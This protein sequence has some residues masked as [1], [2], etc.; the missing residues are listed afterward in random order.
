MDKTKHSVLKNALT[1]LMKVEFYPLSIYATF[2][3]VL[4]F[5]GKFA[6]SPRNENIVIVTASFPANTRAH[7]REI[8]RHRDRDRERDFVSLA[9]WMKDAAFGIL[10]HKHWRLWDYTQCGVLWDLHYVH[11]N[12]QRHLC[13]ASFFC[14]SV[15]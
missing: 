1:L 14:P 7:A 3:P 11:S 6:I 12:S 15:K 8:E 10:C 13:C 2:S 5:K 4:P 9:Y